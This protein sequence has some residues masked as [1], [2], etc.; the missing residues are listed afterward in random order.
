MAI[1]VTQAG[2]KFDVE[3]TPPH[4]EWRSTAA[5][6]AHDVM[7]QLSSLGCH[8]TDAMDAL[9]ESGADWVPEYDAEVRRRRQ[10]G[11]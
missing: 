9:T 2:E 3:V 11:A 5:L 4:G 8:Q 10:Q 1:R 6:T 7:T